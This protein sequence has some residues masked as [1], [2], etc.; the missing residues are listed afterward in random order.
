MDDII[1]FAAGFFKDNFKDMVEFLAEHPRETAEVAVVG[2]AFIA[3]YYMGRYEELKNKN[4]RVVTLKNGN[5]YL[6]TKAGEV[7][8]LADQN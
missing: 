2:V 4:D 8:L 6:V 7:Y 3:G 1:S 5:R